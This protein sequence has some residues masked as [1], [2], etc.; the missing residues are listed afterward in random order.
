MFLS[1]RNQSINS[2]ICKSIDWFLT[3]ALVVNG[4]NQ[5]LKLTLARARKCAASWCHSFEIGAKFALYSYVFVVDLEPAVISY[6]V[7]YDNYRIA[8]KN[9]KTKTLPQTQ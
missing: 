3:E 1:Y 7:S 9:L 2:V 6:Q 5:Y 8:K 4:L